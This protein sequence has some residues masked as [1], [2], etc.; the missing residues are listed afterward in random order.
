MLE[1]VDQREVE[2]DLEVILRERIAAG[3]DLLDEAEDGEP[4]PGALDQPAPRRFDEWMCRQCF[5]IVSRSQFGSLHALHCP[6]GEEPCESIAR[7]V[8]LSRSPL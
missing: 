6:S 3:D 1:T 4:L 5:L 2:A 7:V 8:S